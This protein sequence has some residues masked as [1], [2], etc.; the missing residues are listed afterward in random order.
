MTLDELIQKVPE[1][2]R[3]VA[4][5]YG[6]AL[7]AM[8]TA[9]LWAWVQLLIEGQSQAAYAAVLRRMENPDLL[10]EWDNLNDQWKEANAANA[11]SKALQKEAVL[12]VLRVMLTMALALVG[13]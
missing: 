1:Q 4:A 5:R 10:A 12:A 8:S 2:F 7:L 9:D 11:A 6:P 3:P 13:F